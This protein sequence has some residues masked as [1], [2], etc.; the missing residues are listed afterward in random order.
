MRKTGKSTKEFTELPFQL[1][2]FL[3]QNK[4][5]QKYIMDLISHFTVIPVLARVLQRNK[6]DVMKPTVTATQPNIEELK[7]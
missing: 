2:V 7:E 6:T 3:N 1:C 4:S 5:S